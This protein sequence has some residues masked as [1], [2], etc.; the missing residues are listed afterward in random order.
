[1]H[2]VLKKILKDVDPDI[3]DSLMEKHGQYHAWE[4]LKDPALTALM[5][6]M[7]RDNKPIIVND[8]TEQHKHP[9]VD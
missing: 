9:R 2:E 4:L 7:V 6:Q 3:R 1:M 8:N 5:W